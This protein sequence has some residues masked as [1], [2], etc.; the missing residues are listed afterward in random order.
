MTAR[1]VLPAVLLLLVQC[2]TSALHQLNNLKPGD[3]LTG[4]VVA[5]SGKKLFFDV[6]VTRIGSGGKERA[7]RA[8]ASLPPSHGLMSP[9][10]V[11]TTL[12]VYVRRV[13]PESARL[14]VY[15]R[16]ALDA[17]AEG[18]Q[19][20]RQRRAT[21][22]SDH[23]D[24]LRLEDLA[25]GDALDAIVS[26]V[27]SFGAF[28]Q[29]QVTR[30]GRGGA[31]IPIDMALLPMDQLPDDHF[32]SVGQKLSVR[33]LRPHP[34]AGKLLVTAKRL[35]AVGIR[36]VLE[37]R[38]RARKRAGRRPSLAALAAHPGSTREGFVLQ[39]TDFG[40]VVNVGARKPGLIHISQFDPRG[41]GKGEFV[42]HPSDAVQIGDKVLV[43]VLP[44]SN[45]HRLAL[46]LMKV[47]PRNGD[48]SRAQAALLRRGEALMPTFARAE[49][50]MSTAE[51]AVSSQ[52]QTAEVSVLASEEEIDAA[53]AMR[54]DDEDSDGDDDPFAWA[55]AAGAE[56]RTAT[57]EE[58]DGD[59][60]FAWAAA[61]GA[62][63]AAVERD[64]EAATDDPFAWAAASA[65][66]E[67]AKEQEE[68][69]GAKGDADFGDD[70]DYFYD[71]YDI[72]TY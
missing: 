8:Y 21:A 52:R 36:D 26:S 2:G 63:D 34:G 40:A 20:R 58:E 47:F 32:L 3:A 65:D 46:R 10:S 61:A 29:C 45:E 12:E 71:K 11:G 64:A 56:S 13:Q 5:Q 17:P 30:A 1:R 51:G 41:P 57:G 50:G 59:D 7:V 43:K 72:D 14:E 15:L 62:S 53:W 37:E 54:D 23:T 25:V 16:K 39:I 33:V 27:R 42:S 31:R 6:P 18:L 60:P 38:T 24:W 44:R 22:M 19:I 48:E 67:D 55:A 68:E 35:D 28:V 4:K 69:N 9:R 49:D 66:R 70:E